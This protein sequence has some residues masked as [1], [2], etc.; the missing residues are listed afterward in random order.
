M[1]KFTRFIFHDVLR[2]TNGDTRVGNVV[3]Q[4]RR[5]DCDSC[6]RVEIATVKQINQSCGKRQ[7]TDHDA[8]PQNANPSA[9]HESSQIVTSVHLRYAGP[10]IKRV[11]D[12]SEDLFCG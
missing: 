4:Q 6:W 5:S 7:Q 2:M 10:L 9:S 1:N 11:D 8:T 3:D 12:D